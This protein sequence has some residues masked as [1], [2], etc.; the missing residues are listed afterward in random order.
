M[1]VA[2]IECTFEHRRAFAV[3]LPLAKP[4]HSLT[5][6]RQWRGISRVDAGTR[7]VSTAWAVAFGH[8]SPAH[9][10]GETADMREGN[11]LRAASVAVQIGEG[12]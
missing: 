3:F 9:K 5:V 8:H 10:T 7:T 12:R 4:R 11:S 1:S 6:A 2:D